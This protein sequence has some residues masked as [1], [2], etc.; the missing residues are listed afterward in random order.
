[1]LIILE[2]DQKIYRFAL[3]KKDSCVMIRQYD[4][5]VSNHILT[6]LRIAVNQCQSF[7]LG[8]GISDLSRP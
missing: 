5:L 7:L 3:F 4:G 2:I 1:M 6:E 8:G